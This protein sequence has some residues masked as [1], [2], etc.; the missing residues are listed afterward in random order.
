MGTLLGTHNFNGTQI[1]G[2]IQDWVNT[3]PQIKFDSRIYVRIDNSCPVAISSLDE[4]ECGDK[5][6]CLTFADDPD[7]FAKCAG[8][9]GN[10]TTATCFQQCIG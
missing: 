4:S 2:F 6:G 1:I 3:R 10:T 5:D 9:L 8:K 7:S